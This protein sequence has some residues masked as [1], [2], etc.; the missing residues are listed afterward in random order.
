MTDAEMDMATVI[1]K[2]FEEYLIDQIRK[3]NSPN[4]ELTFVAGFRA[5]FGRAG[6]EIFGTQKV[7]AVTADVSAGEDSAFGSYGEQDLD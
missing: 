3:G 2:A 4:L 5:G 6:E 1:R 7:R